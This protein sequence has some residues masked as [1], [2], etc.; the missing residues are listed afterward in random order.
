MWKIAL[1]LLTVLALGSCSTVQRPLSQGNRPITELSSG[2]IWPLSKI[3]VSSN[4]GYRG[5]DLHA[6]IDLRAP[7]GSKIYASGSGRVSFAGRM[8]GYGLVIVI[9]HGAGIETAYAHNMRNLVSAGQKVGQGQVIATVGRS[10]NATGY[11]VHF[12]VRRG[13]KPVNPVGQVNDSL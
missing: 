1:S 9:D 12:E 8:R 10:G 4:F 6:G 13:G 5:G 7:A 11:H 3:D 2:L